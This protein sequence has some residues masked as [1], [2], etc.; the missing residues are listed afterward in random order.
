MANDE[1]RRL[2]NQA[3]KFRKQEKWDACIKL[4]TE[5]ISSQGDPYG[6]SVAY[7]HRGLAYGVKGEYDRAIEDF[8]KAIELDPIHANTYHLRG[9]AYYN[10]GDHDLAIEDCNKSLELKP[11]NADA[12]SIRGNAYHNK[13]DHDRAIE[14][15]NKT[16]ELDP[17]NS[18]AYCNRG[19]AFGNKGEYD[20]ANEDCNKS[21]ELKPDNAD[22]YF[23]RGLAFGGKGELDQAIADY[24]KSL[25]LK[26]VNADAYLCR[27]LAYREKGKYDRSIKDCNKSLR[28]KPDNA[29]AYYHLG[30]AYTEKGEYEQAFKDLLKAGEKNPNLKIMYP[31]VYIA[32]R[33][34][35]IFKDG[36]KSVKCFEFLFALYGVITN[37][38]REL[39]YR[40]GKGKEVAHYTSL[41]TLK[42]LANKEECFRLYNADYMNDPEEGRIFFGIMKER[43]KKKNNEKDDVDSLFYSNN[44]ET[45][46][47]SSAYIGS[48]VRVGSDKDED[49]GKDELFLWRTYGKHD[50]EEAAGACLIFKHEGIH[51]ASYPPT[52]IGATSQQQ[53]P[54]RQPTKP[55]LYR[56]AYLSECKEEDKE[57][58]KEEKELPG[59][60]NKLAS[61]LEEVR[62]FCEGCKDSQKDALAKL[63]RELLDDIRFLFKA[64][65]YKEEHEVRVVQ[66]AYHETQQTDILID[67]DQFP[68]RLYLNTL[69]DCRFHEVILGPQTKRVSEWKRWLQ[70][71]CVEHVRQSVIK[72]GTQ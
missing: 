24:N 43:M 52:N 39:F 69:N 50:M 41:H 7:Y 27:G 38:K 53:P 68:P 18:S 37:I 30:L 23:Y 8:N 9:H 45:L 67:I 29:F 17:E 55:A 16:I 40:P 36:K 10:K 13:G 25:E 28:L 26:P 3:E 66:M 4:C 11:D 58:G 1:L 49:Q 42:K 60:L 44:K 14:D 51:F 22:A 64:D 63:V 54:M 15:Y 12:H 19:L 61:S 48:F 47:P 70:E 34:K 35:E 62:S 65:H 56:I 32:V 72:Y 21:L 6:Q 31:K 46:Q 71:S 20:R 33:I 59:K 5:Y 2:I 57:K